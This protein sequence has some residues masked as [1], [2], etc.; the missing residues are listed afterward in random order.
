[1]LETEVENA[2]GS[3]ML[4]IEGLAYRRIADVKVGNL[5]YVVDSDR[6]DLAICIEHPPG[7]TGGNPR[8]AALRFLGNTRHGRMPIVDTGGHHCIDWGR[9]PKVRWEHPITLLPRSTAQPAAVGYILLVGE[10]PAISSHY[11]DGRGERMYWN[12]LSGKPIDPGTAD[13]II[14]AKWALGAEAA[15]G[16]FL[17]LACY[18]NDYDNISPA[19]PAR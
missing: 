7:A 16:S 8:N 10:M 11:G 2:E 15:D 5:I 12:L 9:R 13:F 6:I 19:G 1:M 3:W 18:P 4:P 14:L 17:P